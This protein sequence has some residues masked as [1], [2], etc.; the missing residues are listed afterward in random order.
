MTLFEI[1]E[2]IRQCVDE[3][4]G[5]ILDENLLD[6]LAI[7]R[8]E[9]IENV[10]CWCKELSYELDALRAEKERIEHRAKVTENKI[11]GIKQWLIFATGAEKFSTTKAVI[12]FRDTVSVVIDD[13][14][15][16][17]KK[18]LKIEKKVSPM[19][20][21]LRKALEVRK[22]KGCHLETRTSCTVK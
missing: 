15:A 14:T 9:K 5:E 10:A 3:E 12:S 1:D 8:E 17:P 22:V 19:K 7:A 2:R 21:E 13:E 16:I 20:V 18:F 6:S 11:K 4:T